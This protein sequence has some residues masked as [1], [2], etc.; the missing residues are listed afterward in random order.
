MNGDGDDD[1]QGDDGEPEQFDPAA[2]FAAWKGGRAAA[3][4]ELADDAAAVKAAHFRLSTLGV[5][6]AGNPFIVAELAELEPVV[7]VAKEFTE[8]DREAARKHLDL[9]QDPKI[10]WR[11]DWR[12]FVPRKAD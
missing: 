3:L 5:K 7:T 2:V 11:Q 4:A 8:D 12:R 9:V 1:D 10:D 6:S